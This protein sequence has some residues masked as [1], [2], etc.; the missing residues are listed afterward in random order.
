MTDTDAESG[1]QVNRVLPNGAEI[2]FS[3]DR[4]VFVAD[5]VEFL[6]GGLV[7]A[8]SKQTCDLKVFP[9]HVIDGV[10]TYTKHIEDEEWW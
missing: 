6:P 8:I 5:R 4:D 10:H 1:P 7:K 2:H 3:D 9:P